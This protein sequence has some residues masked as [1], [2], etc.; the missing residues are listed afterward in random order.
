MYDW[1][2][3]LLCRWWMDIDCYSEEY[4]YSELWWGN[5][6]VLVFIEFL[7]FCKVN[8]CFEIYGKDNLI[9][10]IIDYNWYNLYLYWF[11]VS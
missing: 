1:I 10:V 7:Y 11:I 8:K 3:G 2:K 5:F 4:C 9:M 6:F